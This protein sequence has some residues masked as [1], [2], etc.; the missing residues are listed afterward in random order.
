MTPVAAAGDTW[1]IPGPAF[2]LLYLL[3]S[4]VV[5]IGTILWR[6]TIVAGPS[7]RR[8]DQPGG[9]TEHTRPAAAA[10]SPRRGG[11]SRRGSLGDDNGL[12]T[13]GVVER[14]R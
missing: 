7:D 8:Y 11:F 5:I 12:R 3:G 9:T 2:A 10:G 1:G 6:R 14:P 4:V 13:G